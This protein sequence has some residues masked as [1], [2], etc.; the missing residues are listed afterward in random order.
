MYRRRTLLA[1]VA[2]SVAP[3]ATIAQQSGKS[4]RVGF[5]SLR[6]IETLDSDFFGEFSRG[7]RELGYIEGKNLVVE[8]R[9]AG[10]KV[11]RLPNLAAG[12][13]Q[14]KVDVIVAAGAQAVRAA[15]TATT[16]IPIV[17]GTAGDPVGS[18]FVKNLAHPGGNITGL[19]DISSDVSPKLL[20]LLLGVV[21]N[22]AHIAVLVNPDN[23][24]HITLLKSV[25][26]AAEKAGVT[27][28]PITARNSR[29]IDAA[30]VAIEKSKNKALIA[31]ADAFFNQQSRQIAEL[32]AKHRVPVISGFWQYVDA[33]GLMSYGQN[34][35]DN[36][37]RA[38]VFVD[39]I[40]KGA[41]PS[42]LPVEQAIKVEFLVNL[43]T[44]KALGLKIPSSLLYRADRVIE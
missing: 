24:S 26:T 11:D 1:L 10:G 33:G 23:S 17:M 18:G 14:Q 5:L 6:R 2:L 35:G 27:I 7:M 37:R 41:K 15:Q 16:R 22:L 30:F 8:W 34:F 39:K 25:R 3:L 36:F 40:L 31:T 4:W 44:A 32:A 42:D 21:P 28:T 20:D 43:R 19:S 13:V 29:E 9:S 38:A 12:L